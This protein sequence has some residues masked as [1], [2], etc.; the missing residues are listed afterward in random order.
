MMNRFFLRCGRILKTNNLNNVQKG[1]VRTHK[2]TTIDR[3]WCSNLTAQY[4]CDRSN[5]DG[6]A[7]CQD[8]RFDLQT[9]LSKYNVS[10]TVYK[11]L[12]DES[13]VCDEL[14]TCTIDDLEDWCNEHSLKTIDRKRF[15]NAIKSLPNAQSNIESTRTKIVEVPV[16]VP[17]FLGNEEKEQFSQFAEMKN[18][19][20][21]MIHDINEIKTKSAANG[22]ILGINNCCDQIQ[23]FVEAL[24]GD[25]LKQVFVVLHLFLSLCMHFSFN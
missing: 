19:V 12:C 25:L 24:R 23:S 17:I 3:V 13:I 21:N 18:N 2:L 9:H 4:G 6:D 11:L 8:R 22:I 15:V 10:K 20:E 7:Q 16:H 5:E 14:I 1:L